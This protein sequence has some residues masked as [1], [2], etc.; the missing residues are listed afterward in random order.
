MTNQGKFPTRSIQQFLPVNVDTFIEKIK[1]DL[2]DNRMTDLQIESVKAIMN[3]CLI[4][5]VLDIRC[6]SYAYAVAYFNC[7]RPNDESHDRIVPCF[8]N[9]NIMTL[10]GM[11]QYPYIG[12]SYTML[13]GKH[14]YRAESIRMDLDLLYDPD[15]LLNIDIASNSHVYCLKNGTIT[16]RKLGEYI[17]GNYCNYTACHR[18]VDRLHSRWE[19]AGYAIQFEKAL[20]ESII[21][22]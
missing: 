12:R 4:Q 7:Y 9:K 10:R 6:V 21:D 3:Q 18:V 19:I 17:Y 5:S 20:R 11:A 22:I 1:V 13:K 16:G 15:L 14:L 8:E 2:F